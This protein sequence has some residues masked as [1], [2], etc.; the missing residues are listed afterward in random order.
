MTGN[1]TEILSGYSSSIYGSVK[2]LSGAISAMIMIAFALAPPAIGQVDSSVD[3]LVADLNKRVLIQNGSEISWPE[4]AGSTSNSGQTVE[5]LL[6]WYAGEGYF[7][8]SVD[9]MIADSVAGILL[10]HVS[11]G[12]LLDIESIDIRLD[13]D[14]EITRFKSTMRTRVGTG[15]RPLHLEQDLVDLLDDLS[16]AG[17]VRSKVR[18]DR[19]DV[20]YDSSTVA[21]VVAATDTGPVM[22]GG[23]QVNEDSRTSASLAGRL[24][25]LKVGSEISSFDPQRIRNRLAAEAFIESVGEPQVIESAGNEVT[26]FLPIRD[27]APG[28]FDLVLGYLPSTGSGASGKI[29]GSGKLELSNVFGG[30]RLFG[31]QLNRLPGQ[32]ASVRAHAEDPFIAGSPIGI[33]FEFNGYQQDSTFSRSSFGAEGSY[34]IAGGLR[35]T[36]SISRDVT[37]PGQAGLSISSGQQRIPRADGYYAGVGL[38][39]RNVDFA[40]NPRSGILAQMN[41]ERGRSTRESSVVVDADTT[42]RSISIRQ[43]RLGVITR[44]FVPTLL[45]QA[46]VIGVDAHAIVASEYRNSDLFRLG[47][48]STLRG[49]NEE[50]F[51]GSAVGRVLAEYRYQL[52]RTSFAFLFTDLGFVQLP[53]IDEAESSRT[54]HPG[55]GMGIQF[56]TTVGFVNASYALNTDDGPTNGKIHIGLSFGL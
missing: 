55:F 18:V 8:A 15:F 22:I 14:R 1:H 56:E 49:Y 7:F 24:A 28:S 46:V 26:V 20:N 36:V 30:G 17:A 33:G 13:S 37:R 40:P 51:V 10:Y 35:G 16:L 4:G 19:I 5:E 54:F 38:R 21:I 34:L 44:V 50:Q 53:Q 31:L 9:S 32:V 2:P 52:D 12:P 11:S 45:R 27:A 41:L 39:Y 42:L 25:E 47:G 6:G 29:V 23:I 3:G 48:A 43:Q